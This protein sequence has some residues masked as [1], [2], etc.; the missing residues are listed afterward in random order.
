MI[1]QMERG[2]S[3]GHFGNPVEVAY[4][5]LY[6]A[7]IE[8]VYVTRIELTVDGGIIADSEARPD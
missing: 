2:I 3:L 7:S 1:E 6:L 5:A 8:S 4:A